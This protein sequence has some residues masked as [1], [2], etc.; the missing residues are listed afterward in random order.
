VAVCAT[1]MAG[2]LQ[3]TVVE[4]LLFGQR[5]LDQFTW[6]RRPSKRQDSYRRR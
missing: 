6:L 3:V 5:L 2:L 1:V 4:C